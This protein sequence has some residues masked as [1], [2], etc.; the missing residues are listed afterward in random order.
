MDYYEAM[1]DLSLARV[2]TAPADGPRAGFGEIRAGG[3]ATP[4]APGLRP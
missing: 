3:G 1:P 2:A 4:R